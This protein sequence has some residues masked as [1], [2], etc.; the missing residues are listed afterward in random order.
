MKALVGKDTSDV[1][2]RLLFSLIFIGLGGEHIFR[3]VLI[4]KMMPGWMPIPRLV[5]FS[6]G[7]FLVAGG[8]MIALGYRLKVASVMLGTFLIV[9]TA[10]IHA[11]ALQGY[12]SPELDLQNQW[13]W[14][15]MQRSNFVKNLCLLGVCV[16]LP[17][18]K[19]GKWSLDSFLESRKG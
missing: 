5:S 6:C 10:L 14:D 8:G 9:V 4:Q 11:P 19:L 1:I 3:D 17:H 2:F 7:I 16:M 13:I 15:T 12:Q 18:Y